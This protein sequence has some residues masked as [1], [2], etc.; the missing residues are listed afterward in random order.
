MT[1]NQHSI[2]QKFAGQ[3]TMPA[4]IPIPIE[5]YGKGFFRAFWIW[6]TATRNWEFHSDW[7]FYCEGIDKIIVI[8]KGFVFDGASIPKR[9]RGYLSP[10][11][12]LLVPGIVHDFGYRYNYVWVRT[13]DGGVEKWPANPDRKFWDDLFF[14]VGNRVNGAVIINLLATIALTLGGWLAWRKNRN[15]NSPELKPES[16][17][18]I[19]Q[20]QA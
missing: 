17:L 5:T 6:Y 9:L 7:N 3:N 18:N 1:V 2:F 12:L 13:E 20:A 10:V 4:L 11:G 16:I 14:D 8:P 19:N 15:R